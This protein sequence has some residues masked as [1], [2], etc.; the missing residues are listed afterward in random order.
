MRVMG[1]ERHGG[2]GCVACPRAVHPIRLPGL[3]RK[4]E[5]ALGIDSDTLRVGRRIT[6]YQDAG[7][8]VPGCPTIYLSFAGIP[9]QPV[10]V[11]EYGSIPAGPFRAF[12]KNVPIGVGK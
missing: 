6:Q 4:L 5:S 3:G 12:G 1:S 8:G 11:A 9:S 7:A 10:R 2:L